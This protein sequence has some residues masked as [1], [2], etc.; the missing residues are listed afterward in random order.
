MESS[1]NGGIAQQQLTPPRPNLT[2]TPNPTQDPTPTILLCIPNIELG[3]KP[4]DDNIIEAQANMIR[5][6]LDK[7]KYPADI[8]FDMYHK[9]LKNEDSEYTDIRN[10]ILNRC[11]GLST[12]DV[13]RFLTDKVVKAMLDSS[14]EFIN[15]SNPEYNIQ[16]TTH[17]SLEEA[18][19]KLEKMDEELKKTNDE[20]E[21]TNDE[22]DKALKKLEKMDEELKKTNDE[23]LLV[24]NNFAHCVEKA[25]FEMKNTI[26]SHQL[27][28]ALKQ[29]LSDQSNPSPITTH[30]T[31]LTT[32]TTQQLTY[33]N[34]RQREKPNNAC[35]LTTLLLAAVDYHTSK[36][37]SITGRKICEKQKTF[38]SKNK[39]KDKTP[40]LLILNVILERDVSNE[41]VR[42]IF[43]AIESNDS[44]AIYQ[45]LTLLI[46]EPDVLKLLNEFYKEKDEAKQKAR[47]EAKKKAPEEAQTTPP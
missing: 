1:T 8:T 26:L 35:V 30:T 40:S 6:L 37:H 7:I 24:Q 29:Q 4:N 27:D 31:T 36:E 20:L 22:L 5:A 15:R 32:S 21:K 41:V 43:F 10:I 39:V 9:I 2:P 23:L 44:E 38:L 33:I 25:E 19:K 34:A 47:E 3:N 14:T 45:T 13:M 28:K 16:L 18:L 17:V 12:A 42:N 46:K 11:L